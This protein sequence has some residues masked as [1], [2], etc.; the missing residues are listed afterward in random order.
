MK[1]KEVDGELYLDKEVKVFFQDEIIPEK[2]K[3]ETKYSL[4]IL[5][6]NKFKDEVKK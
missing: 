1:V 2:Y 6:Y 4:V 3:D 5:S